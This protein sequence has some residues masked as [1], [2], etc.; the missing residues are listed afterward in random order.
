MRL[1]ASLVAYALLL[2][3]AIHQQWRGYD[4]VWAFW[5]TGIA[6]T[7]YGTFLVPFLGAKRERPF[8]AAAHAMVMAAFVTLALLPFLFGPI[9]FLLNAFMP[10]APGRTSLREGGGIVV[11]LMRISVEAFGR[12]WPVALVACLARTA[13]LAPGLAR[14]TAG[15]EGLIPWGVALLL[16]L[17]ALFA[18]AVVIAAM[19]IEISIGGLSRPAANV[20]GYVLMAVILFPWWE[21]VGLARGR[22][23]P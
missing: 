8:D 3:V 15:D 12:Y 18:G 4:F 14:A 2:A 11:D 16:F 17:E 5:A 19:V 20:G 10:I 21:L 22:R 7:A 6:I 23:L 13:W 9:A 1:A